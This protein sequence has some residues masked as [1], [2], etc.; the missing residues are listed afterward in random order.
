MISSILFVPGYGQ[1][2][3]VR[4]IYTDTPEYCSNTS[5]Q[6]SAIFKVTISSLTPWEVAPGCL[7]A[8]CPGSSTMTKLELL[9]SFLFTVN[10][11]ACSESASATLFSTV[12]AL[13]VS[14]VTTAFSADWLSISM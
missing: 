11:T 8:S 6:Y 2:P 12:A 4:V 10:G 14:I 1:F 7:L 3:S 13:S 5:L 9:L